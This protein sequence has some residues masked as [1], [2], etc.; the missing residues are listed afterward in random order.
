MVNELGKITTLVGKSGR[1]YEFSLWSF[2][3]FDDVKSTFTGGGLYLFT[4]RHLSDGVFKHTYIY[5]GE[6]GDYYTRY[7]GHHKEECIKKNHSNCIGFYSMQNATEKERK[8]VEEDL[9]ANYVF[10]C[11]TINN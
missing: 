10:P 6:T 7:D 2:D 4:N 8:E 1:K 3:D 9:L 11:N 5:L